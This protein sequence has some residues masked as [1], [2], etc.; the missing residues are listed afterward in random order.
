MSIFGISGDG[1]LQFLVQNT[2]AMVFTQN[3]DYG[4]T[5]IFKKKSILYIMFDYWYLAADCMSFY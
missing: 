4:M 2:T 1:K 5:V 3:F